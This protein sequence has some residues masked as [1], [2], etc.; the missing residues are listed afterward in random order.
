MIKLLDGNF[1]YKGFKAEIH[2]FEG[3]YFGKINFN[4]VY[5]NFHANNDTEALNKIKQLV[6]EK[7]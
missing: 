4:G 5:E 3:K 7:K 6:D 1:E 2:E